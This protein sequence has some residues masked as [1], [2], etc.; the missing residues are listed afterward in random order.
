MEWQYSV[1]WS[2]FGIGGT[3]RK[4]I[5]LSVDQ[6]AVLAFDSTNVDVLRHITCVIVPPVGLIAMRQVASLLR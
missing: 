2:G 5:A 6:A 3:A 4:S 1:S